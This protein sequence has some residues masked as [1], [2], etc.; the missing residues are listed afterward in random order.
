MKLLLEIV[1]TFMQ[2][3]I[4]SFGGGYASVSL[5]EK[6]IVTIRHWMTYS[7]FADI[8][9]IDELTPGPVAINAA[10][11]VGI[12]MAGVPGAIAATIGTILP[13][14]LITLLPAYLYKRYRDL[15]LVNGA[16]SGLRSMVVALIASTTI[17]I[18]LNTIRAGCGFDFV[19]IGLFLIA[20]FILRRYHVNPILLMLGCGLAGLLIY[21]FI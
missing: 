4:L 14:C 8:V 2:I 10:T 17:S 6:Q 9:A 18:L 13:S 1:W 3:G 20:L 15:T 19:A 11:F 12:R 16:V 7:E 5:V 21:P